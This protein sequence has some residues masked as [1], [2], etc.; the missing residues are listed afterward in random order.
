L[1]FG[2]EEAYQQKQKEILENRG[3]AGLWK[4]RV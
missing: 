1:K 4:K 2:G 3:I